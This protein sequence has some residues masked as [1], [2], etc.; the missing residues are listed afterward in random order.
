MSKIKE[1]TTRFSSSI[2]EGGLTVESVTFE[3]VEGTT[4]R[5]FD[6]NRDKERSFS[7]TIV[8]EKIEVVESSSEDQHT[9]SMGSGEVDKDD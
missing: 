1:E 3:T 4:L 7:D 2:K 6:R 8:F 9:E 5:Y